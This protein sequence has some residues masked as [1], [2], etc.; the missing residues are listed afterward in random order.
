MN[1]AEL[2]EMIRNVLEEE[3]EFHF[4]DGSDNGDSYEA[5]EEEYVSGVG[6]IYRYGTYEYI[7]DGDSAILGASS[8][9]DIEEAISEAISEVPYDRT[10]LDESKDFIFVKVEGLVNDCTYIIAE[11]FLR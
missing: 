5:I 7:G 8:T 11:E 3:G 6:T 2:I 9:V 1:K 10:K 4:S